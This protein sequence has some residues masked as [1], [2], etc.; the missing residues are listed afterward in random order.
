MKV[1]ICFP[2]SNRIHY[3]L[4]SLSIIQNQSYENIEIVISDD[5]S[6]DQTS[7]EISKIMEN[8]KY[9]IIYQKNEQNRGYD[10]NFRK[11]IELSN[12]EYCLVLG[13][14]DS[15]VKSDNIENLVNFLKFNSF[16]DFGF[17]N[18]IEERSNFTLYE[19]A[20]ETKVLGSGPDIALNYY[21]CFSFVGGLIYKKSTF[22]KFNTSKFDGSVFSQIYL[23][24]LMIASGCKLFSIKEPMVLKDIL[25][26]GK[27]RN[28]YR[29]RIAKNWKSF[30]IVDGGFPSVL[31]VVINGLKDSNTIS[32]KRIGFIF[33]RLYLITYPHWILDYKSNNALPEAIGLIIGLF[34]SKNTNFNLLN[35]K[36]KLLVFFIYFLTSIIGIITP[37]YIFNKLKVKLYKIIKK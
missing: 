3:L 30:K 29:D 31:N 32:Q 9:P 5:C 36:N 10:Y 14:D 13:N 25:L 21:S 24:V 6:T 2:Q 23:G 28:S 26:D 34:P 11:C 1:S 20:F 16:P 12:G 7:I 19:R 15:L 22:N 4:K 18:I 33:K 27:F 35:F 8:Y 37:V 17:C